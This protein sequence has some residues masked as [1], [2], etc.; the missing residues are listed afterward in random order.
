MSGVD[1]SKCRAASAPRTAFILASAQCFPLATIASMSEERARKIKVVL[2][3]VDGVLT[4]G[5]IFLFPAPAGTGVAPERTEA[6]LEHEKRA[7]ADAGGYGIGRLK[8]IQGEGFYSPDGT[9]V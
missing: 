6:G 4:D 2:F 1:G 5:H 9:A 3:D 8:T 7:K